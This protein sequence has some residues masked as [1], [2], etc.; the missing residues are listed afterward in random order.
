LSG[1]EKVEKVEESPQALCARPFDLIVIEEC[2][3]MKEKKEGS[4][5]RRSGSVRRAFPEVTADAMEAVRDQLRHNPRSTSAPSAAPHPSSDERRDQ[6]GVAVVGAAAERCEHEDGSEPDH[7]DDVV[8]RRNPGG[9]AP[10]RR[11]PLTLAEIRDN[12]DTGLTERETLKNN[13]KL[14]RTSYMQGF[15]ERYHFLPGTRTPSRP[16]IKVPSKLTLIVDPKASSADAQ[17]MSPSKPLAA[18]AK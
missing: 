13:K 2:V 11:R 16:T 12:M 9:G 18:A 3:R 4:S 6:A 7:S 5:F 10:R 15:R 8:M 1:L 14:F 17:L